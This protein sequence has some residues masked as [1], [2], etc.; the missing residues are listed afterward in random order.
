MGKN[1]TRNNRIVVCLDDN[2]KKQ[3]DEKMESIGIKYRERFARKMLLDGYIINIDM[4]PISELARLLRKC[5]ANINQS[6]KRANESGSVYEDD[7][8]KLLAEVNRLKP[9]VNEAYAE[10]IRLCNK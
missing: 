7:V 6:A 10:I 5:A 4:K 8:L 3:L 1:R 2:E 9:L